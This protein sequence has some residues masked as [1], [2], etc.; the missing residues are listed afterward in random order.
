MSALEALKLIAPTVHLSAEQGTV[1]AEQGSLCARGRVACAT[2]LAKSALSVR[3]IPPP[4][5]QLIGETGS[6]TRAPAPF[7]G[8]R[9]AC[10]KVSNPGTRVAQLLYLF[11]IHSPRIKRLL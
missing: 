1:S 2:G 10:K 4:Y 7:A 5:D 3:S 8:G 9:G 11:I 6:K